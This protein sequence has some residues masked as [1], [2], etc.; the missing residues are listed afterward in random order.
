MLYSWSCEI[1]L[2]VK[3]TQFRHFWKVKIRCGG[4]QNGQLDAYFVSNGDGKT[5]RSESNAVWANL[6]CNFGRFRSDW[7][8]YCLVPAAPRGGRASAEPHTLH[9]DKKNLHWYQYCMTWTVVASHFSPFHQQMGPD[10]LHFMWD[11]STLPW[12]YL[13]WFVLSLTLIHPVKVGLCGGWFMS[14]QPCSALICS[15]SLC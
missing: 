5:S 2:G 3:I 8:K 14:A 10:E 11:D 6:E 13:I 1:V 15:V 12:I 4:G 9:Q 7:D